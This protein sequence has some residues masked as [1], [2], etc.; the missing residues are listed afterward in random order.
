MFNPFK[1]NG[2]SHSHQL[3]KSIPILRDV[4]GI[5]QLYL[6]FN[7]TFCKQ[8]VENLI[9]RRIMRRLISLCTVCPCPTKRT[10]GL[11]GSHVTV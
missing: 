5:F 8:T 4:S 10:L 6:N 2:I 11:Y 3:H 1:P 9:R 7:R